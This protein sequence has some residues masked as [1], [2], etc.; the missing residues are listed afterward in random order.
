MIVDCEMEE[1][2]NKGHWSSRDI[3]SWSFP[4]ENQ[5]SQEKPRFLSRDPDR[6]LPYQIK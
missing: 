1:L 6:A 4:E 2:G 5:E 3:T